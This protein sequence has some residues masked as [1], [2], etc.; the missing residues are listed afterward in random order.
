VLKQGVPELGVSLEQGTEGVPDDGRY[1][2][3]V[4]GVTV[5]SGVSMAKALAEYRK[6]RDSLLGKREPSKMSID[7][8]L[9]RRRIAEVEADRFLSASYGE[10]KRKGMRKGGKAGRQGYK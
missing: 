4:D 8:E 10:R 9:L 1:Y 3:L 5:F 2:V 6:H 7:P